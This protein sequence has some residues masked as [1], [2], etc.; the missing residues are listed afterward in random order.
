MYLEGNQSPLAP[1]SLGAPVTPMV[2]DQNIQISIFSQNSQKS[3]KHTSR[4][5]LTHEENYV[6]YT[7]YCFQTIFEVEQRCKCLISGHPTGSK[8][9]ELIPFAKVAIQGGFLGGS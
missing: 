7:F 9:P 1:F 5:D 8:L 2:L 4:S 6:R 3:N